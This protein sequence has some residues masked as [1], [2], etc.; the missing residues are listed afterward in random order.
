MATRGKTQKKP[1]MK[2]AN[3]PAPKKKPT[4]PTRHFIVEFT[5]FG[6]NK[7]SGANSVRHE[8]ISINVPDGHYPNRQELIQS[9]PP[10]FGITEEQG[11]DET[12]TSVTNIRITELNTEDFDDYMKEI[13]K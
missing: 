11:F 6:V 8:T 10:L 13:E 3:K 5:L 2:V 1:E 7:K 4:K 12:A 9:I